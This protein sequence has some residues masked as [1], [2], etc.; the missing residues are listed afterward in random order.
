[1][2]LFEWQG[3]RLFETAGIPVPRGVV[4]HDV[5]EAAGAAAGLGYP[6]V[7]KAQDRKSVV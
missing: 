7:V 3:K 5:A 1:M 6:V 4:V 2:D